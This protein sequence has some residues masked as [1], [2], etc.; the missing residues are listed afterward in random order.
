VNYTFKIV[1]GFLASAT[2]IC[3]SISS[4]QTPHE[5]PQ[6]GHSGS[7]SNYYLEDVLLG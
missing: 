7:G 1:I 3:M 2:I 4:I 6:S 5:L